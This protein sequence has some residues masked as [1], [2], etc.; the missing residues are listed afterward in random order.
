MGTRRSL[1][2][3]IVCP[4]ASS[5]RMSAMVAQLL[6]L[7][8]PAVA[9]QGREERGWFE[10]GGAGVAELAGDADL[11]VQAPL[12][13]LLRLLAVELDAVGHPV[14][15]AVGMPEVQVP[16]TDDV[17][18]V[19]EARTVGVRVLVAGEPVGCPVHLH[20]VADEHVVLTV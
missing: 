16:R 1:R 10:R 13:R 14:G 15:R 2:T 5:R 12:E 18:Q 19:L 8:L 7:E 20:G 3:A 4:P 6:V 17:A 9:V 11:D